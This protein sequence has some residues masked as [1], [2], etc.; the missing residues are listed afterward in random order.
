MVR[1]LDILKEVLGKVSCRNCGWTW[2]LSDGGKDPFVCHKCGCD[3]S[4]KNE[5][6]L[7]LWANIRA[8]KARGATSAKKGSKAYKQAVKSGKNIK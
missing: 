8:K 4:A 7:G 5:E 3:N 6:R 1:L 2:N